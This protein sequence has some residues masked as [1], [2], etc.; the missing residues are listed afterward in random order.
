[1]E[2]VTLI[3]GFVIG[4]ASA[5]YIL[6]KKLAEQQSVLEQQLDAQRVQFD[7]AVEEK[8]Q[9]HVRIENEHKNHASQSVQI[10][11][12]VLDESADNSDKT[13]ESLNTVTDQIQTLTDMVAMIIELSNSAGK[14]AED[15][16]ENINFVVSDLTNLEKSNADL[17]LILDKFTQV[18][19][20]T[21]AIRYIGEEAEMLALNAAIEAA[22]AGD[23][24]RGFAVVADSIKLLAK[25]SQDTT[26][27]ILDIVQQSDAIITQVASNF[28]ERG[29]KLDTS[30]KSL[31]NNFSQI[32]ISVDTIQ[33]HAKLITGDSTN[34]AT[35]MKESSGTIKTDVENLIKQLSL[36]VSSI[37]GKKIIDLSPQEAKEQWQEFD[38]VIDVRRAEELESD[39]GQIKGVRL[40]TLQ[41]DFKK[42]V[43]KLNKNNRYLFICRSGGRSTKAAQMAITKGIEHVYN[44]DGG[45]LEWRKQGL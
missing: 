43:H 45:M 26:H 38:E 39:L 41:T 20:K 9:F 36:V 29:K 23:A 6:S 18:Q 24:G 1:M 28:S 25:N 22:R 37:T 16:K 34:I 40:S 11:S 44:L 42:E 4:F 32:N 33:S 31:V 17:A 8:E 3:I 13:S 2:I 7:S 19:E 21:V 14:I 5:F 15:G 10:I 12:Q 27:E 35:L 30:I